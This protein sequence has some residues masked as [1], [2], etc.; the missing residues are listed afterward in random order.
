VKHELNLLA[1]RATILVTCQSFLVVPF[2]ILSA[3]SNFYVVAPIALAVTILGGYTA[4]FVREP[5]LAAHRIIAEW[6]Q[7]QRTLLR[8]FPEEYRSNRDKIP[9]ADQTTEKDEEHLRSIAF[10]RQAPTA[11]LWLWVAALIYTIV[12]W[13]WLDQPVP[14]HVLQWTVGGMLALEL[15]G[16]FILFIRCRK[17]YYAAQHGLE[18]RAGGAAGL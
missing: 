7:K 17:S 16:V 1:M 10:T 11:F 3:A 8:D 13:A 5:I 4:W 18:R 15:G 12:R 2:A 6:L 14:E 9:G